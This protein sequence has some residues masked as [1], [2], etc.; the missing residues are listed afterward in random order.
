MEKKR[1][2]S[3]QGGAP[4]PPTGEPRPIRSEASSTADVNLTGGRTVES[5]WD[6]SRQQRANFAPIRPPERP[7]RELP[8]SAAGIGAALAAI[9]LLGGE[10]LYVA[11]LKTEF[12]VEGTKIEALLKSQD[13]W[14]CNLQKEHP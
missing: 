14:T 1:A 6:P 11:G 13:T 9:G 8:I 10:I 12:L 7:R 5:T 3:W 2:P 4:R